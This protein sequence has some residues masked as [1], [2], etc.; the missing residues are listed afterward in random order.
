[1]SFNFSESQQ[2]AY[3]A[4][5][6]GKNVFITGSAG[7]GKSYLTNALKDKDTAVFAP[8]GI[9][10]LNVKGVTCHRGF[11]LPIGLPQDSDFK[12]VY[13]KVKK[14]LRNVDRIIIS[15]IGMVRTDMLDLINKKLQ[16]S[17]GNRKPFGGVQMIVEGDFF[18]LEPI[19]TYK[20]QQEFFKSYSSPFCYSSD[21]WEFEMC[22]LVHPQRQSNIDHYSLL[23]RIRVGED[24]AV[25]DLLAMSK[26]YILDPKTLHLCAYNA[27]ADKVN[28]YW[29]RQNSNKEFTFQAS[30]WGKITERDVIV[31]ETLN[32]KV[33]CKVLLCAN[34]PSGEYVNG[35]TGVVTAIDRLDITVQL[36]NGRVVSVERFTWESYGYQSYDGKLHK[37]VVGAFSQFPVKLGWAVSVHK[38]QGLTLD[39]AAIHTG[40]GMFSHGQFYVAA[41]RIRD[42]TN[43]SFLRKHQVSSSDLIVKDEV[44]RFYGR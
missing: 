35:D 33:G 19:V 16:L 43:L 23:N 44:K 18:Q 8:T 6:S 32:L 28:N 42:L 3:D 2:S 7:N 12:E 13:P 1:M 41:S 4:V 27:D 37:E 15:E 39:S 40:K 5:Q 17:K 10:A 36:D 11:G 24:S 25:D 9:A 29:Y 31:P 21:N 26:D 22:E 34:D 38:S 30:M 20:E 14:V